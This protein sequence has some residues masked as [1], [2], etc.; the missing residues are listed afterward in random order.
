MERRPVSQR[1]AAGVVETPQMS[2]LPSLRRIV[3]MTDL[4]PNWD[5]YGGVPPSARAVAGACLLIE[6]V[7]EAQDQLTGARRAPWTSAPIADGGLQIEWLGDGSRIEVQVSPAGELGYLLV[8]EGNAGEE[9]Q[10][11]DGVSFE[12][13]VE[14]ISGVLAGR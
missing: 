2:L 9:Y 4:P 13:T 7:A 5:S 10:E 14:L 11:A 8:R 12:T 6:A 3:E 1:A